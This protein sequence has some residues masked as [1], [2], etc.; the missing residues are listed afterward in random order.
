MKTLFKL[1]IAYILS[2]IATTNTVVAQSLGTKKN[3]TLTFISYSCGDFCYLELKDLKTAMIYT[4]DNTDEKTKDGGI[5]NEFDDIYYKSGQS[6]KELKGRKYIA[7]I[8]YRQIDEVIEGP[9]EDGYVKLEKTG[10]KI[11]KW[12]INSLSRIPK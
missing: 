2:L 7:V 10:K 4:L 6:D 9:L 12:M 3:I 1:L 8:E 11:S 5:I